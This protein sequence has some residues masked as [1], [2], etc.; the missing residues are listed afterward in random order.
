MVTSCGFLQSGFFIVICPLKR[1]VKFDK[2]CQTLVCFLQHPRFNLKFDYHRLT[3]LELS[4]NIMRI[5]TVSRWLKTV[6]LV[7]KIKH[8]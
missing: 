1:G 4:E 8:T 5:V 3:S 7:R 6:Y 2:T